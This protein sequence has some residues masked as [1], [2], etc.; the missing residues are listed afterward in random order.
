MKKAVRFSPQ[1]AS[2]NKNQT[3]KVH[4]WSNLINEIRIGD[5]LQKPDSLKIF[6]QSDCL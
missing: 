2:F 3:F 4:P 6:S 5:L 1:K